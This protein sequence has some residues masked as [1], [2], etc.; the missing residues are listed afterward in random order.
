MSA[1]VN[2]AIQEAQALLVAVNKHAAELAERGNT[3][4]IVLG[5]GSLVTCM[6]KGKDGRRREYV[7]ARIVKSEGV[8]GTGW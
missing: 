5:D 1:T 4:S 8:E 6:G 3:T 7:G 2:V